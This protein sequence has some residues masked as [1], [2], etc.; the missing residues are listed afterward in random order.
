MS[1]RQI[2]P[3]S[4]LGTIR[5]LIAMVK[6][7]PKPENPDR[8]FQPRASSTE[9]LTDVKYIPNL[10]L[11]KGKELVFH[12]TDLEEGGKYALVFMGGSI[13]ELHAINSNCEA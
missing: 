3:L 11:L 1:D 7:K 4:N 2:V 12:Y 9:Y 6:L 5:L 8:K 13:S 10:S